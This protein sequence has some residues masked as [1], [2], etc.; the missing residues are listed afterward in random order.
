MANT[1]RRIEALETRLV[2]DE[3][4][5]KLLL[6]AEN[7]SEAQAFARAGYSLNEDVFQIVLV[8]PASR[9]N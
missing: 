7:E 1:V 2:P 8:Q 4:P 5:F 9:R 6:R 3:Q